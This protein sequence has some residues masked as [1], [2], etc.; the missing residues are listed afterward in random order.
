M[1][2][3]DSVLIIED[4]PIDVFIN[5]RVIQQ[6]GLSQEIN[7]QPSA[8]QALLFLESNAETEKLPTIIFLDI[9]MP[10]MDGFEFLEHF[11]LLP[12]SIKAKC[13]IVM[14][15]STIDPSD[16]EKARNNTSVLA[17]I[18]KPLTRDKVE[19]LFA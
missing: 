4:N 13:R 3:V 11:D 6:S 15:S 17:F 8:R 5:T 14:L 1:N 10:D 7:A 2:S 12:E 9:R 16:L 19:E 18:P